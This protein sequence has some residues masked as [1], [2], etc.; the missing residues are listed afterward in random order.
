MSR[1][2]VVKKIQRRTEAG[3]AYRFTSIH[4]V[5]GKE[6]THTDDCYAEAL[7]LKQELRDLD[8][9]FKGKIEKYDT[10]TRKAVKS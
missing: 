6:Q 1:K 2:E 4:P 3:I 10:T 7:I 9:Q 8:Y 5:T